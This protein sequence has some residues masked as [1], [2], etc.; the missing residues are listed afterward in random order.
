MDVYMG[1]QFHPQVSALL[2]LKLR[3]LKSI[4]QFIRHPPP[5]HHPVIILVE[6]NTMACKCL[7]QLLQ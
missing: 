7:I 4:K 5:K 1:L 3:M 6:I 2:L